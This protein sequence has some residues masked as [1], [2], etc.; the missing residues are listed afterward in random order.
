MADQ[1]VD[2]ERVRVLLDLAGELAEKMDVAEIASYVLDVGV[3]SIGAKAASLCLLVNDEEFEIAG[4]RGYPD[5]VIALWARFP[6]DASVPAADAAG[7]PLFIR[8]GQEIAERYPLF[9][10]F[11]A[12][13]GATAVLPM[14]VR[15]RPLGALSFSFDDERDFA[16]EEWTFL[17]AL[18]R[19]CGAALYRAAGDGLD[20]GGDFYD[21]IARGSERWLLVVGDVTGHGVRAAAVTGLLRH[22]IAGAARL[23]ASL[24]EILA[25]ANDVLI[26]REGEPGTFATVALIGLDRS[27]WS[28][29][30]ACAGHPRRC[31]GARTAGWRSSAHKAGCS[32][33]STTSTA[34]RSGRASGQVTR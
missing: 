19:H 8:S 6:R 22:T 1:S 16:D 20:V 7:Q 30:I 18:A 13:Q 9:A 27:T 24:R 15:R 26:A 28:L 4:Q 12:D 14:I 3:G 17:G 2:P 32:G 31:C 34:T 11:A 10:P 21:V 33:S 5:H 23:G 29:D 25:H